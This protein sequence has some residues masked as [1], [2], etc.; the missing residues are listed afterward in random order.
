LALT[1]VRV[2][3]AGQSAKQEDIPA[4]VVLFGWVNIPRVTSDI[5]KGGLIN[6]HLSGLTLILIEL[7]KGS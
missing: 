7:K 6:H 1:G 4:F 2:C 5:S 3:V